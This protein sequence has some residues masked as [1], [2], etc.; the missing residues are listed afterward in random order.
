M[1]V[2]KAQPKAEAE[3]EVEDEK[4]TMKRPMLRKSD[5]D[6]P[7]GHDS[8]QNAD[9]NEEKSHDSEGSS[10]YVASDD[11]VGSD[12]SQEVA[13]HCNH[14]VSAEDSDGGNLF[15]SSEDSMQGL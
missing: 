10:D 2:P 8:E 7:K 4:P 5:D 3:A 12:V 15:Y 11:Y 13:Y 1:T 6:E 14:A 9:D